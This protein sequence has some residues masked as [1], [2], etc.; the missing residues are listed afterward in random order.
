MTTTTIDYTSKELIIT[1]EF[2]KKRL[3]RA[4]EET[5]TLQ[6]KL[7][8]NKR[9]SL[10]DLRLSSMVQ[11]YKM[12]QKVGKRLY[13]RLSKFSILLYKYEACFSLGLRFDE[14]LEALGAFDK[15]RFEL[16]KK[17]FPLCVHRADSEV[18][19]YKLPVAS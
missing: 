10:E 18:K 12:L 1:I 14:L 17:S 13:N 11:K 3:V 2:A 5:R 8:A 4:I 15:M 9:E 16:K 6:S 7:A 19:I